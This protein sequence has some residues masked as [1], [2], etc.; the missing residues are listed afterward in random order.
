MTFLIG[1]PGGSEWLVVIFFL[2]FIIAIPVFLVVNFSRAK[3][4]KHQLEQVTK[5][6]DELLK[7]L[8]EK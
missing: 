3:H 7:K 4:Y 2:L 8:L 6:R 5:E 1:L